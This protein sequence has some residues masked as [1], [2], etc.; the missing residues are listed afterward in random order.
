MKRVNMGEVHAALRAETSDLVGWRRRAH[1]A[2]LR[3]LLRAVDVERR[4][5]DDRAAELHKA[6]LHLLHE[7]ARVTNSGGE[8]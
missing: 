5:L 3:K 8:Q 6:R 7:I 1:L 2:R 4:P